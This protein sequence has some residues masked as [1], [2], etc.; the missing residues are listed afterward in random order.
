MMAKRGQKRRNSEKATWIII[1]GALVAM[2]V[3]LAVWS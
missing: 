2:I 3:I 1:G